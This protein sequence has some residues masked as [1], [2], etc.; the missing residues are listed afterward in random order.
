MV[1]IKKY[2]VPLSFKNYIIELQ[3]KIKQMHSVS[4]FGCKYGTLALSATIILEEKFTN[5]YKLIYMLF[6]LLSC[7]PQLGKVL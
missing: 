7:Y 2:S 4:H 1:Y 6:A 3:T 5:L